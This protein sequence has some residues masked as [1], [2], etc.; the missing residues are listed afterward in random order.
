MRTILHTLALV[1]L[2]LAPLFGGGMILEI[3]N[4]KANP[5]AV[6]KQGVIL[7][8]LTAC[9]APAKGILAATAEGIVAGKRLTL[10]LKVDN[11]AEPGVWS[12][13]R[14]WPNEGKWVVRLV[15][16]HPEYGD[17]TSSVIVGVAGDSFDWGKVRRFNGKPPSA[18]DLAGILAK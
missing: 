14:S 10:P 3:G 15:A 2:A 12:I 7:A 9:Q 8:R 11:L 13:A 16:S 5:A 1:P 17:H 18:D 6:A 4:A